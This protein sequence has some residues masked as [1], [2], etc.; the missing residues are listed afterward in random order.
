M[1]QAIESRRPRRGELL[2][3]SD[4]GCQYTSGAFQ[5]ILRGLGIV[6]SMS[7]TGCCYD[8]AVAERFFWSLKHEWTNHETFCDLEEARW[9]VF[10]Y[11]DAF[12]NSVR[13][14]QTLDYQTPNQYED[15]YAAQAA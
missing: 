5:A 10:H 12:Y 6:C 11:I 7:R 8:N 13:I 3:H 14:H 1:K 15:R 2:H 4:R 9:S